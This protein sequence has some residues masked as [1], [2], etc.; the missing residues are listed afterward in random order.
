MFVVCR[1]SISGILDMENCKTKMLLFGRTGSGM[2]TIANMLIKG[3]LDSPL[4]FWDKLGDSRED[5]I[6]PKRRD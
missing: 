4:L 6:F 5:N 3:N 1:S 2:S